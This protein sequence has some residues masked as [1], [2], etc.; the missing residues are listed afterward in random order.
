M[1]ILTRRLLLWSS[2]GTIMCSF[3]QWIPL[4]LTSVGLLLFFPTIYYRSGCA[5]GADQ[6]YRPISTYA[7]ACILVVSGEPVLPVTRRGLLT[8][9]ESRGQ[10][11]RRLSHLLWV[12]G[13]QRREPGCPA[14]RRFLASLPGVD[15]QGSG[16]YE[17]CL[18]G[19]GIALVV[20]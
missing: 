8:M 15:S 3:S 2:S 17:F 16:V 18:V 13:R 6:R 19:P 10:R 1:K 7:C 12:T 14:Q 11:V 4:P 20:D 5:S 9:R